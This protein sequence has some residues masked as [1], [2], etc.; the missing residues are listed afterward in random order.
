MATHK[1]KQYPNPVH[2]F[3]SVNW[4]GHLLGPISIPAEFIR[5]MC[6]LL[7]GLA[8]PKSEIRRYYDPIHPSPIDQCQEL[9]HL[10]HPIDTRSLQPPGVAHGN[11]INVACHIVFPLWHIEPSLRPILHIVFNGVAM[12]W[13]TNPSQSCKYMLPTI[14]DPDPSSGFQTEEVTEE[15]KMWKNAKITLTEMDEDIDMKDG[16]RA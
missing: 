12:Y 14:L 13:P 8:S 1:V 7:A 2:D 11:L 9:L 15:I 6:P 5:G 4:L 10:L 16:I 3:I